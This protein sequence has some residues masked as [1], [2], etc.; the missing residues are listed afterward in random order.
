MAAYIQTSEVFD[1]VYE[2]TLQLKK[3]LVVDVEEVLESD[4]S[5]DEELSTQTITT[6]VDPQILVDGVKL[7]LPLSEEGTR[8]CIH[9]GRS[10]PLGR[11]VWELNA[12]NFEISNPEFKSL[13]DGAEPSSLYLYEQGAT[14][15]AHQKWVAPQS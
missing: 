13:V 2:P 10:T 15:E 5:E 3:S 4:L 14:I 1:R 11:R 12:S 8:L 7:S 9:V 6:S